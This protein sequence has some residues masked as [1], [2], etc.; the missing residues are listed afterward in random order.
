MAT[1]LSGLVCLALL[2]AGR[3]LAALPGEA[4]GS[5]GS[6]PAPFSH[7]HAEVIPA[8]AR[9]KLSADLAEL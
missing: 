9:S 4:T 7:C 5:P 6:A 8:A 3:Q 2:A 1:E